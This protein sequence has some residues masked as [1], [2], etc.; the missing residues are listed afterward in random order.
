VVA[1]GMALNIT[2]TSRQ[3]SLDFGLLACRRTLPHVQRLL[4]YL[5]E[6]LLE[7]EQLTQTGPGIQAPEPL[8]DRR[9]TAR[10]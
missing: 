3:N 2:V 7:I 6:G 9:V 4:D 10:A 1:D 8:P 5:A